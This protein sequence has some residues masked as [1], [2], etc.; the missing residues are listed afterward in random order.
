MN[1]NK[2]IKEGGISILGII[3]LTIILIFVLSYFNISVK[4]VV[5]SPTAKDNVNY[6]GGAGK[7]LWNDYLKKPVTYFWDK[8]VVDLL[9]ASFVSNMERIRDGQPTDFDK[10]APTVPIQ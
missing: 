7:N 3:L 9:W 4:S 5:E 1:T 6:V 8:V 2:T 10:A